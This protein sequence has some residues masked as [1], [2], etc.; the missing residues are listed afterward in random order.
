MLV[1][2]SVV[3][4][5]LFAAPSYEAFSRK[6][7]QAVRGRRDRLAEMFGEPR[8]ASLP[9]TEAFE[10]AQPLRGSRGPEHCRGAVQQCIRNVLPVLWQSVLRHD[11]VLSFHGSMDF[12]NEK[13]ERLFAWLKR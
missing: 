1:G 3:L 8:H 7:L 2:Q 10:Q 5:S 6:Q 4:M 13:V 12:A 11:H 9:F